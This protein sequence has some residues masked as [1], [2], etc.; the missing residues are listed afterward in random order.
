MINAGFISESDTQY[1][2]GNSTRVFHDEEI[3]LSIEKAK[4]TYPELSDK[5]LKKHCYASLIY[6]WL[7]CGYAHEYCPHECVTQVPATREKAR[8]SYI[9]RLMGGEIKR[10]VSFHLDYLLDLADLHVSILPRT[11]CSLPVVWWIDGG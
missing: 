2:S 10:M 7:R 1:A 6:E 4:A 3:D 5:Q 9:G 8:V 11:S